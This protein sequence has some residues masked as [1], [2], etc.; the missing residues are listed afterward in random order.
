MPSTG[1]G[2]FGL[3]LRQLRIRAGLTQDQL[4]D[5]AKVG[6]SALSDY[7]TGKKE[8]TLRTAAAL[9]AALDVS[10]DELASPF[11]RCPSSRRRLQ[12]LKA[13]S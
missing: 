4:S 12:P 3:Q 2:T 6:Q 5:L 8:P 11:T 1:P 10:L 9:A 7:E 13:A